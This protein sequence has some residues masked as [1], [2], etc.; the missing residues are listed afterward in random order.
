LSIRGLDPN[1]KNPRAQSFDATIEQELPGHF[2]VSAGYVGNYAQ[3]L[4]VFIDTN[5]APATT[6]KSYDQLDST[7]AIVKTITVPWYTARITPNTANILTGFSSIDSWY[8]SLVFTVRK[9]LSH[10][11]SG[12]ANYTF[13][14]ANDG[15]QVSGVNGTF[16]GTDT[17]ID[18]NNLGA[19]WGRSDL[20]IRQRFTGTLI[21]SPTFK[22][23]SKFVKQ[24]ANG[25]TLSA[26]YTVQA[27]FPVTGFMSS[28]PSSPIGD[29]GITGAEL[30]L[31]NSGTGGRVPQFARNVFEA[32]ALQNVDAR[33]ARTFALTEK[34]SLDIFAEAFNVTNSQI[35]VNVVSS[36][37]SYLAAGSSATVNGVTNSC[38]GHTN[39]C[40]V[41][42]LPSNPT[43][44]FK[45]VSATSGVL[46]GP[47]QMQFSAKFNF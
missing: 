28:Y 36:L 19:E 34:L 45:A 5:V 6:T 31:F 7:G 23:D 3:F 12:L 1:F 30:S 33:L 38:V 17:P 16:N 43:Q 14:H 42:Y 10:G 22:P 40:I 41:P 15:G 9:P 44:P 46:Y 24:L 25:W 32:P 29:G 26:T 35:P 4:P 20:D 13:A 8:H 39:D 37:S 47:R 18:P 11:I 27:G 21:A 2:A